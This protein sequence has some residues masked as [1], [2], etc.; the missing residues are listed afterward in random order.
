MFTVKKQDQ[1]RAR[2]A[3]RHIETC[4]FDLSDPL[5]SFKRKRRSRE[6]LV[7]WATELEQMGYPTTPIKT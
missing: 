3:A 5:A 6:W 1:E 2:E 4:L 7:Y